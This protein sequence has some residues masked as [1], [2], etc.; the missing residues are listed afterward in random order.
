[1]IIAFGS[2]LYG[3]TFRVPGGLHVSTRFIHVSF[4]PFVPRSSWII[5]HK[6]HPAAIDGGAY[7]LDGILWRSAGLAWLRGALVTLVL[8]VV[9]VFST[10]LLLDRPVSTL[11]LT[12]GIF[13]AA[14][15]AYWC[16]YLFDHTDEA[17]LA[18]LLHSSSLPSTL[19]PRKVHS[20]HH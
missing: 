6:D 16:T 1:M 5:L 8:L 12:G 2:R 14:I 7:Q 9:L 10:Q 3:K 15:L 19:L 11:A 18:S 4:F 13:L 20:D 17:K